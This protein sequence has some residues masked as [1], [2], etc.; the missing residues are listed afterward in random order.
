MTFA[1][2]DEFKKRLSQ[3]V[4]L[5]REELDEG[6]SHVPFLLNDSLHRYFAELMSALAADLVLLNGAMRGNLDAVLSLKGTMEQNLTAVRSFDEASR[7]ATGWLIGLTVVLVI[8][9]IVLAFFT[10]LLWS[11]T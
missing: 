3:P 8:L 4:R 1:T 9:T 11:K 7:K 6:L 10:V 2:T 5:T